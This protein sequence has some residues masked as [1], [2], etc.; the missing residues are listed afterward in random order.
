MTIPAADQSFLIPRSLLRG[1]LGCIPGPSVI[2]AFFQGV[3]RNEIGSSNF[4]VLAR[5]WIISLCRNAGLPTRR[6]ARRLRVPQQPQGWWLSLP[7]RPTNRAIVQ[8]SR[9]AVVA[10]T[11][12]ATQ[13]SRLHVLPDRGERCTNPKCTKDPDSILAAVGD[14]WLS[15]KNYRAWADIIAQIIRL[16]TL[17]QSIKS[18]DDLLLQDR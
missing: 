18:G 16:G 15:I 1:V 12:E 10:P 3:G 6:W 13:R 17:Y 2:D 5:N 9:E 7:S 8:P 4:T 14:A 11:R